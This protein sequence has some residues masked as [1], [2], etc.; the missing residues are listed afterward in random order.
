MNGSSTL[1]IMR[2]Y[3]RLFVNRRAFTLQSTTPNQSGRHYYYRPKK[4]PSLSLDTI[5][6]HLTG[7]WTLGLYAI[8]PQTQ[9]SK[10]A[11]IDADYDGSMQHLRD[12][13]GAFS[14]DGITAALEGSRRGGHLW[15]F[16]QEPLS[17]GAWRLY[18]LHTA[19]KLRIPIKGSLACASAA[20][21]A[22]ATTKAG[23]LLDGIEVIPKQDTLEEG[24]FGNGLRGPLGIHR[25]NGCRYWFEGAPGS[26]SAQ[27][28]YLQALPKV[29][30]EQLL[31]LTAGLSLPEEFAPAMRIP[32]RGT[33][34]NFNGFRILDHVKVRYRLS[35]NYWARCPSCA[36]AGRDTGGNN[37][38]IL[39]RDSRFYRCWAGCTREMIREA[40]GHPVRQMRVS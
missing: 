29:S 15:M 30:Q 21:P 6:R 11:A 14:Q 32:P 17:A 27:I 23:R 34:R 2:A 22:L 38:A 28:E 16:G 24:E 26:V 39:I 4:Q 3:F 19:K 37:L 9:R 1:G 33:N 31:R 40:V 20:G 36:E 8:N 12:L 25:A 7:F 10:W 13:Q 18:I 35:R 5:R